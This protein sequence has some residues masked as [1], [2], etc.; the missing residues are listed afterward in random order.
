MHNGKPEK[1]FRKKGTGCFKP[2]NMLKITRFIYEIVQNNKLS[3]S[4]EIKIQVIR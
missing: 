3:R 4:E 2:G 1:L